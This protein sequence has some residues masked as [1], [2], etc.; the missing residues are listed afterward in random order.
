MGCSY[1]CSLRAGLYWR[2]YTTPFKEQPL[3]NA[4]LWYV[5]C[6]LLEKSIKFLSCMSI[7]VKSLSFVSCAA[8]GGFLAGVCAHKIRWELRREWFRTAYIDR[9]QKS[10]KAAL[11]SAVPY[12]VVTRLVQRLIGKGLLSNFACVSIAFTSYQALFNQFYPKKNKHPWEVFASGCLSLSFFSVNSLLH[13]GLLKRLDPVIDNLLSG[14]IH[15]ASANNQRLPYLAVPIG[16]LAGKI[17]TQSLFNFCN[18]VELK[19][20][21]AG[22]YGNRRKLTNFA[23]GVLALA[24]STYVYKSPLVASATIGSVVYSYLRHQTAMSSAISSFFSIVVTAKCLDGSLASEFF[25]FQGARWGFSR[26]AFKVFYIISVFG[27]GTALGC[28]FILQPE[29]EHHKKQWINRGYLAGSLMGMVALRILKGPFPQPPTKIF[30]VSIASYYFL[31]RK[32]AFKG[33]GL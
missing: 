4:Q 13:E 23:L 19:W 18:N 8:A 24:S 20:P 7:A 28:H 27:T 11:L 5:Y 6:K 31:G 14:R 33:L 17:L 29:Q 32:L 30:A 16:I 22:R 15:I 1:F 26:E 10:L 25:S 21:L 2:V 3:L 9:G 12:V